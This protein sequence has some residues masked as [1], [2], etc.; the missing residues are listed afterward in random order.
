MTLMQVLAPNRNTG[1]CLDPGLPG[2]GLHRG[3]GE[4]EEGAEAGPGPPSRDG[5]DQLKFGRGGGN[6]MR[7]KEEAIRD[8]R[9]EGQQPT[10]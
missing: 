6:I 8:V 9:R 2:T 10:E 5:K 1:N 4:G 7:N 3:K